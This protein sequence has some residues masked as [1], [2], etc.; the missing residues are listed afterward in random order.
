MH[1]ESQGILSASWSKIMNYM[2]INKDSKY[3]KVEE[4][5]LNEKLAF[6]ELYKKTK[7]IVELLED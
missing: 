7:C 4:Q 1:L 6:E 2:K 3:K 5:L